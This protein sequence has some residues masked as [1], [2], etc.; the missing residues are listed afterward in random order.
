MAQTGLFG[1]GAQV[2]PL[3]QSRIQPTGV[4]GSTFVRAPVREAGGNVRALAQAL[5]GLNSALLNYGNVKAQQEEDPQSREN[6]AW[7]AKRQQMSIEDLRKEAQAGTHD[8]MKVREDALNLLLGERANDDFRKH[9]IKFYNTEFDRTTGDA[10]G[11]YGRL[12]QEYA[13]RLP[14][15]IARGNFFRLTGDHYRAWMEKDTE[16]KVAYVKQEV[17]TTIVDGFRNTLDDA[18]NIHGKTPQE[19]VGATGERQGTKHGGYF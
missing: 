16:E 18:L 17:N 11:E 10:A 14:T 19:V 1:T 5:G 3:D 12:R 15:E 8:G 4:P 2:R 6:R 13:E 7:I 9:W